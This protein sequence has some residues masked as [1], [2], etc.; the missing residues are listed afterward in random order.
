MCWRGLTTDTI[1]DSNSILHLS[2][3]CEHNCRLKEEISNIPSF[4]TIFPYYLESGNLKLSGVSYLCTAFIPVFQF[5]GIPSI[6]CISIFSLKIDMAN[7]LILNIEFCP[8]C[9]YQISFWYCG[10]Q[11][12][13]NKQLQYW[14]G[15]TYWNFPLVWPLGG[16]NILL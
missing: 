14:T 6:L 9:A 12:M 7:E 2:L 5:T 16:A 8:E 10:V 15:Q 1:V 3:L 13:S 11:Q 4:L